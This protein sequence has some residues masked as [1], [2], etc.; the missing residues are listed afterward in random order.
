MKL[1]G[2]RTLITGGGHGLG[3]AL[4][5]EFDR[6]GAEVIVAD[7]DATRVERATA[8]LA[9]RGAGYVMDVTV[10]V[11]V[12]DVRNRINAERGPIDLLI[13]NAGVVYG[14]EFQNV[15]L[16]LHLTTVAVNLAGLLTVTHAFLPD[17]IARPESRLVNIASASA[18]LALPLAAS[19]AASKWGVLGFSDSLREELTRAG[20][21]H[22]GVTAICP[23][24]IATGL[25]EG[26]RPARLTSMLD[27]DSVARAVRRA[28][29]RDRNF[30]MLPRSAAIL[31]AVIRSLPRGLQ[32]CICRWL[33]VSD[34]MAGWRGDARHL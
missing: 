29:Q 26:A 14:G 13:N 17:L 30:V 19:Y 4:V 15:P 31:H 23:S 18:L 6:A 12:L 7:R 5:R 11:Q 2:K 1:S 3:L 10:P 20:H 16:E 9:G 21:G 27:P 25:F 22:V 24:Y 32:T 8:E 34:S 28:V 33:G